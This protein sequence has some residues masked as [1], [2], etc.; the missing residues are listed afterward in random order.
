MSQ[1]FG[2]G[3][4]GRC[5]RAMVQGL[6]VALLLSVPVGVFNLLG[7][8]IALALGQEAQVSALAGGYLAALAWGVPGYFLFVALK[9]T[10]E[11]MNRPVAPMVVTFFGLGL[12][13]IANRVL[14]YGIDGIVPAMGVVGTGWATTIVRWSMLLVLAGWVWRNAELR[15]FHHGVRASPDRRIIGEILIV[16][17]PIGGQVSLEAGCFSFAAIMM[18]W[19][20]PIELAAHQVTINI[21]ATTF[22]VA[23]GT[24]IAGSVRVG[25]HI[26]ARR[27]G[28]V[29]RA[30]LA[31]YI[32]A[33]GF[34][35]ICALLFVALPHEL[36]GLYTR[37]AE[38]IDLGAR[39]LIVAAAFQVF[40]GAQVAGMSVLRGAAD[41][42]TPMLLAAIGYWG[43]GVAVGY[44]L[45]FAG[46]LG[47]VGVWIGLST[48]LATVALM[49][50]VRV[51]RTIWLTPIRALHAGPPMA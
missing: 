3:D 31:T 51:R 8:P 24:S 43:L 17:T 7:E 49:L 36:I 20:G 11:A 4:L 2:A 40:D 19:L 42:R 1:A 16:G 47:A 23:L 21:A 44:L 29:R 30:A 26:G 22:M 41:T 18:G 46:G 9:Q 38:L 50:G 6:W 32:L 15:P 12:N 28:A 45:A 10:L 25:Q 5:R 35:A 34:M 39:L 37:D 48:G 27:P 33:V 14:I 13:I